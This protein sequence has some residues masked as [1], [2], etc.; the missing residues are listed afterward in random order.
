MARRSS[1]VQRAL[2]AAVEALEARAGCEFMMFDTP[3]ELRSVSA[4]DVT[5]EWV[6]TKV[7]H[8][9]LPSEARARAAQRGRARTRA[10]RLQHA[11]HAQRRTLVTERTACAR[12]RA[13]R[14]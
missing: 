1:A 12:A 10:R 5:A 2:Q 8:L 13:W 11:T 14:R 7:D 6:L 4:R 3:L 9:L